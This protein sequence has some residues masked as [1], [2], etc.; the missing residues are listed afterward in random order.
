MPH[1]QIRRVTASQAVTA[2]KRGLQNNG[3]DIMSRDALL[4]SA[5]HTERDIDQ[6]LAAF[7]RTLAAM[8]AEGLA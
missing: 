8:R 2:L 4:V 5:T 6:T 1:D 7:E 3:V